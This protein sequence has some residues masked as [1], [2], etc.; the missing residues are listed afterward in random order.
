MPTIT[1]LVEKRYLAQPQPQQLV[2]VL[3]DRGKRVVLVHDEEPADVWNAALSAARIVVARGRS[4]RLLDALRIA[5]ERGLPTIDGH[6][7]VSAVRDKRIMT[8]R[9]QAAGIPVPATWLGSAEQI[10]AELR[11]RPARSPH[12]IVKPAFGDNSRGISIINTADAAQLADVDTPLIVQE[13]VSGDGVDLKLYVIGKDVWAVRKPSPVVSSTGGALGPVPLTDEMAALARQCG[14]IFGLTVY[15]V[16][17]IQTNAGL[18][19]IEVNDFPNYTSVPDAADLLATHLEEM[20][21]A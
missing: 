9:L 6:A 3:R 13:L 1:V 8:A 12:L 11:R 4:Q 21:R 2:T 14:E 20:S 5:A 10:L 17:C 19:V 7:S 16:D 18:V 15:G